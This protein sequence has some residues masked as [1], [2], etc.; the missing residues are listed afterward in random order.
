MNISL[1]DERKQFI[2]AQVADHHYGSSSDYLGELILK[3][4]D[5][6]RLRAAMLEGLN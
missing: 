2:D 1:P 5:V 3:Q 6:A 4:R